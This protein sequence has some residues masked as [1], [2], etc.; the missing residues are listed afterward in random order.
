MLRSTPLAIMLI[1]GGCTT[2]SVPIVSPPSAQHPA[3]SEDI[4]QPA[5]TGEEQ[6]MADQSVWLPVQVESP[7]P[8]VP[9][10]NNRI[11]LDDANAA[12]ARG[13]VAQ[14]ISLLQQAADQGNPQAHYDLAKVFTEGTIAV[15]DLEKANEHLR[16]AA[17]FGYPE[18]VRVIGWQLIRGD[19][20]PADLQAGTDLIERAA[21]SSVR[22]QRE[23]GMLFANLYQYHLNDPA[24]GK[25]YLAMASDA[26]DSDA[27]FQLGKL[28]HDEGNDLEAVPR[29]SVAAGQGNTRAMKLLRQI[30]PTA[31][32]TGMSTPSADNTS[33]ARPDSERLYQQANAIILRS[34]RTLEQEARAYAMFAVAHDQGHQLAGTELKALSGV[35][36]LMDEQDPGWLDLE[37]RKILA[38]P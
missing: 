2:E 19:T 12:K 11:G 10:P 6:V 22:A 1:L 32:A 28:Y 34:G 13:D 17:E 36:T 5:N 4:Y 27:S 33:G 38:L 3:S 14:Y 30:D 29:L 35:K 31:T 8:A 26:G 20:G 25:I 16:V 37:K 9:N 21:Q 23:A 24:K 18:A 15:R 7:A